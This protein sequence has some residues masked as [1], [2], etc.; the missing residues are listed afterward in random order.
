MTP[1]P[2]P[3]PASARGWPATLRPALVGWVVLG[4]MAGTTLRDQLGH[5]FPATPGG[6]PWTTFAINVSGAFLLGLLLTALSASGPDEGARRAARLGVGTGVVG[7]YTTYS[8]FMVESVS[9]VGGGHGFVALVYDAAS[10]VAGFAA[11]FAGTMLG[12]LVGQLGTR[13]Q[14]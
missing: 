10:L 2:A 7:G 12:A 14:P 5:M 1:P 13:G 6:W 3:I 11:A 4:G 8:S 9:L